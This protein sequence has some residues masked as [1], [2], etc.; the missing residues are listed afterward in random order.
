M[1][2]RRIYCAGPLFT[3]FERQEMADIATAFESS[4][5]RTFL[6]HRDGLEFARLEPLPIARG[7]SNDVV[8]RM[9]RRAIFALDTQMVLACDGLVFNMNGRVPDEGG[10]SEAAIAWTSGLP[11]VLYKNDARSLIAGADNPLVVGLGAFTVSDD[12]ASLPQLMTDAM[13]SASS[14]AAVALG[15]DLS[16]RLKRAATIDEK[17]DVVEALFAPTLTNGATAEETANSAPS[18]RPRQAAL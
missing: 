5:F 18:E 6:P 11:V 1:T 9:L 15:A 7:R 12:V 8:A 14:R 16:N 10:V 13:R 3:A 2:E 17:A 4:G